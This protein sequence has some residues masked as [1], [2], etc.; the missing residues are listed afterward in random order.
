MAAHQ[1]AGALGDGLVLPLKVLAVEA[2]RV[3]FAPRLGDVPPQQALLGL[4]VLGRQHVPGFVVT[5]LA[6][7]QPQPTPLSW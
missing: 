3:C 6:R 1:A 2:G 4:P 5:C 7:L